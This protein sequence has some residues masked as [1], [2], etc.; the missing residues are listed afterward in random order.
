ML[1]LSLLLARVHALWLI[2][3]KQN[4]LTMSEQKRVYLVEKWSVAGGLS[5]NDD[6]LIDGMIS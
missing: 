6:G 3:T 5:L 2:K 4:T 1:S